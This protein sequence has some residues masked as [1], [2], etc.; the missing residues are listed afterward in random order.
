MLGGDNHQV[1]ALQSSRSL[2]HFPQASTFQYSFHTWWIELEKVIRRPFR[3][4]CKIT[5][6]LVSSG[7]SDLSLWGIAGKD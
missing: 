7:S 3:I 5:K 1:A 4:L 6:K 2:E